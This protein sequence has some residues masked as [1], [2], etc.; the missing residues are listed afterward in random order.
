MKIILFGA[1]GMVGGG[2]L[3]ECL[4]DARVESVL[5]V[6]RRSCELKHPKLRELLIQDLFALDAEREELSGF[7]ACFFCLGISSFGVTETEYRRVTLE[8]TMEIA[9]LLGELNPSI[10]FCY[11]SG[12]GSDRSG[13]SRVMWARVKGEAENQLLEMPFPGYA[14]R[15]GIIR[16]WKGVS[17]R[18]TLYKIAYAAL[19]P[20]FPVVNRL[21]PNQVTTT[22]R[23]ARAMI[24][25][26][27]GNC[28]EHVLEV[29]DINALGAAAA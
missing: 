5:A 7:D 8:L 25:A 6:G 13:T 1:T 28:S 26:A 12:Q 24:R 29:R 11:V 17:S 23:I 15:P 22:G 4:N 9:K 10:T 14:F 2:V 27:E 19:R 18:T 16:P 20:I 21:F 3:R